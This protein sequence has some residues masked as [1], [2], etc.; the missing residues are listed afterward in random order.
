MEIWKDII[1]FEGL[2]QVS[3]L[4]NIKS[5]ERVTYFGLN[6]QRI[7][8]EK[9][10]SPKDNTYGYLTVNLSNKQIRKTSYIHILVATAFVEKSDINLI[11]VNHKDC[12][13]T[14]NKSSNL[15]WCTRKFN[16]EHSIL[17]KLTENNRGEKSHF[18]KLKK[19][20]VLEIRN[21]FESNPSLLY[22]SDKYNVSK[23][24]ISRIINN[25][26]WKQ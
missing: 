13:K 3:N 16:I 23:A 21:L 25:K 5:L 12:N 17:N 6:S 2:Y 9:L 19:E 1:N 18:S 15:E 26:I 8:E 7:E 10:L 4:G 20:Q 24:T 14:N 22:F 11:E